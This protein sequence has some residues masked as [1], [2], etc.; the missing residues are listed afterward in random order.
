M[1][2]NIPDFQ[3]DF[4]LHIALLKQRFLDL[5][6]NKPVF[7]INIEEKIQI[8]PAEFKNNENAST[9]EFYV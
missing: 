6:L 5:T 2:E 4:D 8:S 9:C 1:A 3:E 7:R